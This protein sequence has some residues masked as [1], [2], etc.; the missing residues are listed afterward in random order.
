VTLEDRF[1]T[2]DRKIKL[3]RP[4]C[5]ATMVLA[6]ALLLTTAAAAAAAAA[7]AHAAPSAPQHIVWPPPQHI[8]AAGP[9]LALHPRFVMTTSSSSARLA[10]AIGRHTS[11]IRPAVRN[12]AAGGVTVQVAAL[13]S[14]SLFVATDS[15]HLGSATDYSYNLTVSASGAS[16][17]CISVY[18]CIYALESFT[19]LLDHQRG[20]VLHSEVE[21]VDAPDYQWRGIMLDAGRRFFPMANVKDIMNVMA[22][23]KLNVLH[24]HASDYCRFGVESKLYP[25][26][27]AALTGIKGG[28][29]T[30]DDIKAM[31]AYGSNLGIRVVPEFDVRQIRAVVESHVLLLNVLL[32]SPPC[33][34]PGTRKGLNRW[35]GATSRI[36]SSAARMSPAAA[37]STT[38]LPA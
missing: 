19:Q 32:L 22:A 6:S 37:S 13:E 7:A 35:R 34:S 25:N 31:I 9:A 15:E 8:V 1:E 2:T 14:L 33:R 5:V 36:S 18:G 29:Y 24:L 17:R 16:A 4:Y 11:I 38:T 23:N 26:L 3:R 20:E 30:Q 10:V 21:I 28:F 27:T 12:A